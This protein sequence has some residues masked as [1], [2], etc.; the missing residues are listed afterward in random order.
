[1]TERP[2]FAGSRVRIKALIRSAFA[3][4]FAMTGLA[5]LWDSMFARRG[6]RILAYHGVETPVSNPF[7]VSVERFEEQMAYVS[8]HFDV[9]DLDTLLK[10]L[11]GSYDSKKRKL[12][13]TFDDGFKNNFSQAA[14]ILKK[15]RLSATF[16]IIASKLDGGDDRF[17][18]T[19]D[20]VRLQECELFRIGSHSL[21]HRSMAQI[22]EDDRTEEM[23][24]SKA[25]LESRLARSVRHFCYPYGTFNDFDRRSIAS[26]QRH[27]YALA[28]T[29]VNGVNFKGTDRFKLRRTK[30]EW[31][32]DFK[33]FQRA[34]Y[35]ALDAWI[36]IDYFFR[37]LQRP[38]AVRFERQEPQAAIQ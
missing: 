34:L 28:C 36:L 26:L 25:L 27:G 14:P 5:W 6:L 19:S 30:V 15:Y 37:F 12:V 21:N 10:W 31:S 11:D 20:A 17:M 4:V 29:S 35:G 16:F 9:M 13:L 23:G 38:R 24:G 2:A 18:M 22:S 1:M 8:R 3:A 7:C 32:D 33:T